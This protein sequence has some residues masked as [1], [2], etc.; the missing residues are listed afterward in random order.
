MSSYQ[1]TK[2]PVETL[3]VVR[4]SAEEAATRLLQAAIVRRAAAEAEQAAL[5]AAARAAREDL[6]TRRS[7]AKGAATADVGVARERYWDRLRADVA[8]RTARAA[9]HRAGPL[10][11]ARAEVAAAT[12]AHRTARG[13]RELVEKLCQKADGARRRSEA[14]RAEVAGDDQAQ[15]VAANRDRGRESGSRPRIETINPARPPSSR[16][17]NFR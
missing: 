1:A 16:G 6:R 5:D 8:T 13:A 15:I 10:A 14:R 4:R 11:A 7:T 9:A 2:T 17:S 3:L 12:A